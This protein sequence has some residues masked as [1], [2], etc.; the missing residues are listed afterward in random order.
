MK[1]VE[2]R[3]ILNSNDFSN[4]ESNSNLIDLKNKININEII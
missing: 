2:S 3:S 1:K 4:E